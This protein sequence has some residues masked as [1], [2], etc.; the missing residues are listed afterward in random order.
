MNQKGGVQHGHM[1]AEQVSVKAPP[2]PRT[3][4]SRL[5]VKPVRSFIEATVN[6]CQN[7]IWDLTELYGN[8]VYKFRKVGRNDSLVI[9][10]K[11]K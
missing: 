6:R 11:Y 7:F 4:K 10:G 2:Q 3:S 1:G 9:S 5:S 8:L